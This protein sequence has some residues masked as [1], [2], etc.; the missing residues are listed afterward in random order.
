ML[1][2]MFEKLKTKIIF[3]K[4]LYCIKDDNNIKDVKLHY[5]ISNTITNINTVILK[6]KLPKPM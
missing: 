1:K 4:T 5:T 2:F 3:K 6:N